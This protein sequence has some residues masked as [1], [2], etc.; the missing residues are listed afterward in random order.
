[1]KN[2]NL[3]VDRDFV[4]EDTPKFIPKNPTSNKYDQNENYIEVELSDNIYNKSEFPSTEKKINLEENHNLNIE[5]KESNIN[6]KETAAIEQVEKINLPRKSRC[7]F[8]VIVM[9]I[10]L[11]VNLENGTIPAATTEIKNS[12]L[13]EEKELGIFGS[14]LYVGNAIG[15]KFVIPYF[16]KFILQKNKIKISSNKLYI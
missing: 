3:Q 16:K 8:F 10:N 4:Q 13:I 14:L 12:L 15:K 11:I 5:E 1:M 7:W 2:K 6:I 9:F